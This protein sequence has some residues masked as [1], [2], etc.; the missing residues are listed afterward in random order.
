MNNRSDRLGRLVA[1]LLGGSAFIALASPAMAQ[2]NITL[3]DTLVVGGGRSVDDDSKSIVARS[4]NG[5]GKLATSVLDTPAS[6][7]VITSKEM[8]RRGA[9]TT[10]EMLQYT[11]GTTTDFYGTDDRN[12]FVKVRGFDVGVIRDGAAGGT[13]VREEMYAFERAEV[14]KGANSSAFGTSDPGGSINYV[15]KRPKS[16]KFGEVYV[17]GGTFNHAQVGFDFGDNLTEDDT[18]SYRLVGKFQQANKEYDYARDHERFILGGVTWR[19]TDATE[20][21]VIYDYLNRDGVPGSGGHPVGTDLPR[22][23]FLGEPDFNYRN[24]SRHTLSVL[25]DHDFGTGLS[26][27]ANARYTNS[28]SD[29]GYAY[30]ARTAPGG[31]TIAERDFFANEASKENFVVD[32]RLQYETSWEMV[33]SR[34]LVGAQYN[35][36]TSSS[37]TVS[38]KA[39]NIDW[40]NPIYSGAPTTPLALSTRGVPDATNTNK[41]TALY[42]EQDLTFFDRVILSGGIR[43]DWMDLNQRNNVTGAVTSATPTE[44]TK[45]AALTFKATEEISAYL[46]YAESAVPAGTGVEPER[47][48]QWEVGV[49]YQPEAF[50]ALFTASIFELTKDNM[51]KRNPA[52]LLQETIGEVKV[53]GIELEARAE[54]L[55]NL[56]ITASYAYMMSEIVENGVL[57][58]KGNQLSFVPNHSASLWLDYAVPSVGSM[59]DLTVGVGARYAGGHYLNDANTQSAPASIE[60]DAALTYELQENTTLELNVKNIFDEKH[61]AYG[62]FGADFYNPGR[63]ITATLR[64]SW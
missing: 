7:A 1:A 57:A 60:F 20:L 14:L 25:F 34:T 4:T 56:S 59:G 29:F 38:G 3:L 33:D 54:V 49:K 9:T 44:I 16:E 15:T 8:Q 5:A 19:P 21:T 41:V 24:V 58:N 47:G 42:V 18:L 10:E 23:L 61:V 30:I 40:S 50:P 6:I 64:K 22:N 55:E 28:T 35:T 43:S 36:D 63:S 37:R 32:G 17:T 12:D 26:F 45:R 31:G 52:T 48:N 51:T 27:G 62:G 46:S 53:R 2:S 39:P 11:A 13:G